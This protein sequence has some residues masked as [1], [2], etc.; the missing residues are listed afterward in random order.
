L[1]KVCIQISS[2]YRCIPVPIHVVQS[3]ADNWYLVY[4]PSE[5]FAGVS[6][7]GKKKKK[8]LFVSYISPVV[9]LCTLNQVDP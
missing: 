4:E 8:R 6:D 5:A 3:T 2:L 1:H 9:G 7:G